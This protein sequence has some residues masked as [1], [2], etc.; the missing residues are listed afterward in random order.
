MA[1]KTYRLPFDAE[2]GRYEKEAIVADVVRRGQE[3]PC[4]LERAEFQFPE[5]IFELTVE[6]EPGAEEVRAEV[7]LR[8]EVYEASDFTTIAEKDHEFLLEV[9]PREGTPD[10][11]FKPGPVLRKSCIVQCEPVRPAMVLK[12]PS[13]EELPLPAVGDEQ[14]TLV[15]QVTMGGGGRP[16]KGLELRWERLEGGCSVHGTLEGGSAVTDEAGEIQLSYTAPRLCYKP[17]EKYFE[18]YRFLGTGPQEQELF[19]LKIPLAPL[20][21]YRMKAEKVQELDG[22][23]YGIEGPLSEVV[24][25]D[26]HDRVKALEG[27]LLLTTTIR[28]REQQDPVADMECS[29][30]LGDENGVP[31]DQEGIKLTTDAQGKIRWEIPEL[32]AAFGERGTT[33]QLSTERGELPRLELTEATRKV[34]EFYESRFDHQSFPRGVFQGGLE[35]ELRSYRLVHSRQ[36]ASRETAAYQK[37][38]DTLEILSIGTRYAGSFRRC[39]TE[40]FSPLLGVLGDTFW[41]YFNYIWNLKNMAG[42]IIAGLTSGASAIARAIASRCEGSVSFLRTLLARIRP[43][44]WAIDKAAGFFEWLVTKVEGLAAFAGGYVGKLRQ[45]ALD[46][47]KEA[48]E[49][50]AL[51]GQAE[52]TGMKALAAL[53]A[54]IKGLVATVARG[55]GHLLQGAVGV[56]ER[57]AFWL[58]TRAAAGLRVFEQSFFEHLEGYT[59]MEAIHRGIQYFMEA[60]GARWHGKL[61]GE[62]VMVQVGNYLQSLLETFFG[63]GGWV[64]GGASRSV[65][66]FASLNLFDPAATVAVRSLHRACSDLRAADDPEE[67]G[68]TTREMASSVAQTQLTYEKSFIMGEAI[69]MFVDSMK[70]PVQVALAAVVT[71]TTLGGGTVALGSICTKMELIISTLAICLL[72]VPHAVTIFLGAYLIQ[73]AYLT[74]VANLEV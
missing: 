66:N 31:E 36:L 3:A 74:A 40:Q 71:L 30:L 54:G 32:A 35:E 8:E 24:E 26:P 42:K 34:L 38:R 23:K 62:G 16:W 27:T 56:L 39:F 13:E 47:A 63:K 9:V 1:E 4:P 65:S 64:T 52:S 46:L 29:I 72:D 73:Q 49:L 55:I 6:F 11:G 41:D 60:L 43:L 57:F 61:A 18:E 10:G 70:I 59:G 15:L 28:G 48:T 7:A 20:I 19:R 50:V 51:M 44:Q 33:R 58:M 17:G 21:V 37:I 69:K 14:T 5:E 2:S 25:I 45:A 22:G 68:A 67:K 53:A 12:Q